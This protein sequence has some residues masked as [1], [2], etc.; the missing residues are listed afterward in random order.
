MTPP[1]D[2]Q[3]DPPCGERY[4]SIGGWACGCRLRK[5]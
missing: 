5:G 3:F 1:P 2:V 4:R